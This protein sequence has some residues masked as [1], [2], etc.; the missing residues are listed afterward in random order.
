MFPSQIKSELCKL[1]YQ[2]N[3]KEIENE[4]YKIQA[5]KY[6][7][8]SFIAFSPQNCKSPD[9]AHN[10][11]R[12]YLKWSAVSEKQ[13]FS[14]IVVLANQFQLAR[15]SEHSEWYLDGTFW[16]APK[17]FYQLV[18]FLVFCEKLQKYVCLAQLLLTSKKLEEYVLGIQNLVLSANLLGIKLS[19]K[20]LMCD[21]ELALRQA[22]ALIFPNAKVLG[23][24]FH[25]VKALWR[26]AGTLGL[27]KKER[28]IK[29]SSVIS[30]FVILAHMNVEERENHFNELKD[31]YE[32]SDDLYK[33]FLKYFADSW[34]K[35]DFIVIDSE[36]RDLRERTN[37]GC[38]GFH[39]YLS[40]ILFFLNLLSSRKSVRKITS[41]PGFFYRKDKTV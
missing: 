25:F 32:G 38:E 7:R 16:C 36:S 27:K 33:Q 37:N 19:P 20:Y 10:I 6:P 34:L 35:M 24:E 11:F 17:G 23:C 4:L 28:I 30:F 22:L 29:T 12:G 8:E 14:E 13:A 21:F 2:T 5:E 39:S 31:I 9:S 18:N 41:S 1:G 40:I 26:K 3:Q 15:L